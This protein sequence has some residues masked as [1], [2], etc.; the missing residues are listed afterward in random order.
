M[1]VRLA[2]IGYEGASLEGFLDALQGAGVARLVDVRAV[3][4]SRRR[5]FCKGALRAALAA[6]GIDYVHLRGLG[7][8][9][10]GRDA[11]KAGRLAEYR[12]IY[13]AHLASAEAA[14]DL[15]R[16]GAL[17][18]D[19]RACLMCLERDPAHCHRLMVVEVLARDTAL[20]VAHLV[21]SAPGQ[22]V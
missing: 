9:K 1:T 21:P 5:E 15:E 4:G 17:A 7:N 22:A 18:A 12:A 2:T 20:E 14:A 6:R 11:A 8:P 16:L 19:G 10:P 13:A 3:P